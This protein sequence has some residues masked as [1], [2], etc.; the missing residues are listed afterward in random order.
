MVMLVW[1]EASM[2][3]RIGM[4]FSPCGTPRKTL[5]VLLAL[6]RTDPDRTDIVAAC[7]LDLPGLVVHWGSTP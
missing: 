7:S 2:L 1:M 5:L 3:D 4:P 6:A